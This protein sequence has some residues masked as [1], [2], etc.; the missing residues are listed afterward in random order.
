[1]TS[2]GWVLPGAAASFGL[3]SLAL[4]DRLSR[5]AGLVAIVTGL[6]VAVAVAAQVISVERRRR[7]SGA[8]LVGAGLLSAVHG[9]P[10]SPRDRILRAAGIGDTETEPVDIRRSS[11]SAVPMLAALVAL[12]LL[13]AGWAALRA[14]PVD[15]LSSLDGRRVSFVGTVGSDVRTLETG[16]S[17]EVSVRRM[18][19]PGPYPVQAELSARLWVQGRG[20]PPRVHPGEQVEVEGTLRA[21]RPQGGGFAEYLRDRGLAATVSTSSIDVLEHPASPVLRLANAAREALRRGTGVA[22]PR[23]EAEL[24]LGLA[25]GDTSGMDPEVEEDFRASGLGHLLAVSG[26]NVAMFLAPLLA[27]AAAMRA[28][29]ATRL[30]VGIAGVGFFALVTRWEPSVLRA[31]AM[32]GLAL[33]GSFAGRPRSS[34]PL[35]GGA[36]LLLLVGD[37]WLARSVGFQLSVA[38]TAGIVALAGPLA[39]RLWWLPRPVALAAAATLGAQIAVTPLLLLRFGVVPTATLLANLLAFPA[40]PLSL[41]GGLA[42]AGTAHGWAPAGRLLGAMAEQPLA[43]IEG[44]A[45]RL[46]RAPLPQIVSDGPALPAVAAVLAAVALWRLRR[47]RRPIGGVVALLLVGVFLWPAGGRAGPPSALTVTFLDVGQ[48]DAAVVRTPDGATVLIDSGPDEQQVARELARLRVRRIDLAVAS[49]AHADHVSGFP[50]IFSRFP[51]ALLIEPGCPHDA[52]QYRQML[53]SAGSEGIVVRSP[54][55]GERLEVGSLAIEV[56]GPEVCADEEPNDNSLV[57][58]LHPIGNSHPSSSILFTGDAEEPAQRDLL[59][60]GD[61]LAAAVLKVPHQGGATSIEEFFEA[62]GADVA[63]VS[64]G[65]NEYGHPVPWVLSA[66]RRSGGLVL[67]TDESG[68]VTVRFGPHGVLVESGR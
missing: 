41:L 63:V 45:D 38:A 32:A 47:G 37:P 48:G 8:L 24:L 30:L 66:L 12:S 2:R 34:A 16:W 57:L 62:V 40:V 4:G 50:A 14:P 9:R 67:R 23:R 19:L 10:P 33:A 53:E 52:P 20:P 68:D 60:D 56:L 11:P 17:A 5:L 55:G 64:V 43:Y 6:A 42:A 13:G 39:S 31:S 18:L 49:H 22:L 29:S 35:L 59:A 61:P 1:M 27:V 54:R 25:I 36:V 15:V 28:S 26:S 58:L 65:P 46:A 3:G 51:V 7:R 21:I 44:V